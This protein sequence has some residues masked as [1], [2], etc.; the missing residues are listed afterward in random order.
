MKK[1]VLFGLALGIAAASAVAVAVSKISAEMK[2]RFD[3]E[4]FEKTMPKTRSTNVLAYEKKNFNK[5]EDICM[6]KWRFNSFFIENYYFFTE[7]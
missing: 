1:R 7:K 3:E 6:K 4:E 2:N 5:F